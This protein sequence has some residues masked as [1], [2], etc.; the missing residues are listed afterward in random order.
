MK[1]KLTSMGACAI[2]AKESQAFA[3]LSG[4]YNPLHL[5]PVSARRYQFGSTLIHGINGTLRALDFFLA[6]EQQPV[7]LTSLKVLFSKP[8]QQS[9]KME[10]LVERISA[11]TA[12]IE[13]HCQ[14]KK[15]QSI[16]LSF[17]AQTNFDS[18][19]RI[20]PLGE[21]GEISTPADIGIEQAE[22]LCGSAQLVWKPELFA[23]LFGQLSDK[24]PESQCATILGTTSIVGMQ[25]P[26]LN[27]VYARLTLD[28]D[29]DCSAPVSQL[30]YRVENI[31]PRFARVIMAV[32]NS[33]ATGEIEAF[34]RPAPAEQ[35]SFSEIRTLVQKNQF[36]AQHALIIGG[37]RGLGEV[38]AKL[39]AAGGARTQ[40]TFANGRDDALRVVEDI[41]AGG[42]LC[43]ATQ[44]NV[45][46]GEIPEDLFRAPDRIT[47]I[48]YM[49]SPL[50]E[51][52]STSLWDANV[53]SKFVDVY[54]RG[55][56]DLLTPLTRRVDYRDVKLNIYLP[57][58]VFLDC[59]ERG[60]AEYIVAKAAVES[61]AT[62]LVNRYPKWKLHTP[63]LP[64]M[65]TDQTSG[66]AGL[67]P[68]NN[69]REILPTLLN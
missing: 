30:D 64:R 13:I 66:V 31:D 57:S 26:G 28:L 17:I 6:N 12:H 48:Y 37:S 46:Y 9:D 45:L 67:D 55:L 61:F 58:T 65:L 49:A 23:K 3:K 21:E 7:S 54:V 63:R 11:T 69:A 15:V 20:P 56:A 24:V 43:D 4:D 33:A 1:R 18:T 47:H 29:T 36:A 32:S 19:S 34:F 27:S 38:T 53:F 42:G 39:L 22:N 60:F 59:P 44:F 16:E 68:L 14:G 52:N 51:K 2:D 50:I 10:F 25:C 35:A 41:S 5:D 40:I 62:Q 8:V